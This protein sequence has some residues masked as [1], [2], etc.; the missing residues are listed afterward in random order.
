MMQNEHIESVSNKKIVRGV[1]IS[2]VI[3]FVNILSGLL[4]TP[5]L[6]RTLG[7]SSFGIYTI[8]ISLITLFMLDFGLGAAISKYI[9]EHLINQA[10][11]Q[12]AHL[13]G[14]IY[15]LYLV[16]DIILASILIILY[17]FLGSIFTGLTPSE[18]EVF[19]TIFIVVGVFTVLSFP[20][21]SLNGILIANESFQAMKLFELFQKV[22]TLLFMITF[23]L[24]NGDLITLI[25]IHAIIGLFVIVLKVYYISKHTKISI[26]FKKN[27]HAMLKMIFKISMWATIIAISERLMFTL[28]PTILGIVSTTSMIA[29]F[30]VASAIEGYLYVVANAINGFFLPKITRIYQH[31]DADRNMFDL[32]VRLG[33]VQLIIIL[34]VFSGFVILGESFILLWLDNTYLDVY[35]LA[36]LLMIPSIFY[37]P[38]ELGNQALMVNNKLKLQSFVFII[39]AIINIVFVFLLGRYYGALGAVISIFIAYTF[40]TI[41]MNL[42]YQKHLNISLKSYYTKTY[43]P[44][45]I[46]TVITFVLG[47]LI[48]MILNEVTWMHFILNGILITLVFMTSIYAFT[49]N[50]EEKLQTKEVL[51]RI[52]LRSSNV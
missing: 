50:K 27:D 39:M 31:E 15:K 47:R 42:I 20:F 18:L 41:A 29:L 8:A 44:F 3:I 51:K 19:R 5:F 38:Q 25:L 34:L 45:M 48:S 33:R 11:E 14:M 28:S 52:I 10:Y 9:S 26:Q 6:I 4:F 1:V 13:L 22:F 36:I 49:L 43:V 32:F 40:R 37:F 46:P 2:Y 21:L 35:F 12:I 7:Q 30:G 17:F 24:F 16:I 23:L